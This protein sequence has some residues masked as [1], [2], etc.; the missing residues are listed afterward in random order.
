[1]KIRAIEA[2]PVRIP[3]ERATSVGTAG[4]PTGLDA[5][6]GDYRWSAVFPVLYA[7]N[8]ETALVRVTLDDGRVGWGEAQAPLAPEVACT[9]VERLLAPVLVN[10]GFDGT[11]ENIQILWD[12]MYATMR[13]RG[14]TG[15]FMLDAISGIDLALWDLAGKIQEKPV[16]AL[17]PGSLK[18]TRVPAYHSGVPGRSVAQRIEYSRA[19]CAEGF[20]AFKLFYDSGRE[21]FLH[22]LSELRLALGPVTGLAVDALWRLTPEDAV[23]FGLELD[24]HN[25]LWLEAPLPPEDPFAHEALARQIRTPLALG[26]SYRTRFELAP[27]FRSR[28]FRYV[29]PDLGRSGLTEGL[30]IAH[31]AAGLSMSVVPHVSIAMGPQIAAAIHMAAALPNCE[32][33]E[34]NPNV[35][36]I[37]NRYLREPLQFSNGCYQVPQTPGLGCDVRI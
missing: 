37:A 8:F 25:A 28:C 3:R 23:D 14:Q 2:I 32:L 34:Y 19:R 10:T 17:I 12:R 26:E 33:L 15:G 29:Q 35:F 20:G 6:P 31:V 5:T 9:I 1:V 13:V 24:R 7:V 18:R 4:S 22:V 27:F 36:E 30:H 16:A 11:I 21:E